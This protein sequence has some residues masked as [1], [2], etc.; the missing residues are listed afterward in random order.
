MSDRLQFPCSPPFE[1]LLELQTVKTKLRDEGHRNIC[2]SLVHTQRIEKT[3]KT[4]AYA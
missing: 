4:I 1:P 3:T 2:L